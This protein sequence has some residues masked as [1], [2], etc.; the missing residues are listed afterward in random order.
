M[1]TKSEKIYKNMLDF[2]KQKYEM[3]RMINKYE[4]F[5]VGLNTGTYF[6]S[7]VLQKGSSQ[8]IWF[9]KIIQIFIS[10]YFIWKQICWDTSE[11]YKYRDSRVLHMLMTTR[12]LSR[13]TSVNG[14]G[15]TRPVTNSAMS[16]LCLG[17]TRPFL[18]FIV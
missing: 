3:R 13:N 5:S 2:M 12:L 6:S 7:K 8:T 11:T 17:S 9:F 1:V 10:G 4:S 18:H 16:Q 14:H 15:S